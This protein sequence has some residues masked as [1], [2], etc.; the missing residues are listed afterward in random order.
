[1]LALARPEIP[2]VKDEKLLGMYTLTDQLGG[3][4]TNPMVT[5][6]V[7]AELFETLKKAGLNPADAR[8]LMYA[9]HNKCDRFVT[10]DDHFLS[11]R[12]VGS[13]LPRHQDR[14]S[15]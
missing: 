11:R 4:S 5:E 10:T 7:D 15:K 12:A 1:M 3:F 14:D 13:V 8:H 6:Y 2:L 9:A